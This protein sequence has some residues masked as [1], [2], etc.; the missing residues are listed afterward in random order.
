MFA[1][2]TATQDIVKTLLHMAEGM[3][4]QAPEQEVLSI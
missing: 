3:K 1:K 2:P 4:K